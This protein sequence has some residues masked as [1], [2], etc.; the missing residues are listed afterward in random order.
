M[1]GRPARRRFL[2]CSVTAGALLALPGS[3]RGRA[4]AAPPAE[5]RVSWQD[6]GVRSDDPSGRAWF[7]VCRRKEDARAYIY[8]GTTNGKNHLLRFDAEREKWVI[9]KRGSD[10]RPWFPEAQAE[11]PAPVDNGYSVWDNVNDELWVNCVNPAAAPAIFNA[12]SGSWRQVTRKEFPSYDF[13]Q[14][15]ALFNAACDSNDD[16][17]VVYGGSRY[18]VTATLRVY[19]G[20]R[21][22]WRFFENHGAGAGKPGAM[23]TVQN[24]LRWIPQ[25]GAFLLCAQRRVFTLSPTDWAWRERDVEGRGHPSPSG[26]SVVPLPERPIVAVIGGPAADVWLLDY[27]AWRWSRLEA[28]PPWPPVPRLSGGA[29]AEGSSLYVQWGWRPGS[30]EPEAMKRL[31]VCRDT[32]RWP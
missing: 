10:G 18:G 17:M 16:T 11:F 1:S 2:Q 13:K 9:H 30:D 27:K 21:R 19:D 24:Q 15:P 8:S 3:A 7:A 32:D 31:F 4:S 12:R 26:I 25:L 29:W 14:M 6:L 22:T 5:S 28:V 20:H 23:K